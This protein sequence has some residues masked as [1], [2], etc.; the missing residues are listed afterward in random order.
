MVHQNGGLTDKSAPSNG[1]ASWVAKIN[2][3]VDTAES[4]TPPYM[5]EDASIQVELYKTT[6]RHLSSK[7]AMT[8]D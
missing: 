3:T 1:A 8:F 4:K 7:T 5:K 2:P 6:R